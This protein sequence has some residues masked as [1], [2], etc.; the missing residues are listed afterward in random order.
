MLL[1]DPEIKA[2]FRGVRPTPHPYQLAPLLQ[3]PEVVVVVTRSEQGTSELDVVHGDTSS[4]LSSGTEAACTTS[5]DNFSES[6]EN[7]CEP[8]SA[9]TARSLPRPVAGRRSEGVREPREEVGERGDVPGRPI[10]QQPRE[11]CGAIAPGR[12][13]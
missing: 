2:A 6:N 1:V 12:L 4:K 10:D 5:V 11:A 9:G 8:D 13:H 7:A 3:S